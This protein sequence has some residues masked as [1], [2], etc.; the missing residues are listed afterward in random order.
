MAE[1][2]GLSGPTVK[3]SAV[4]NAAILT[5]NTGIT[6]ALEVL[7][8]D[9]CQGESIQLRLANTTT[10]QAPYTV[11]VNGVTYNATSAGS[12]FA[13]IETSDRTI[14][15]SGAMP[16][17]NTVNDGQSIEVGVKFRSSVAGYIKGIRFYHGTNNS[18][19]YT[20]HL[21]SAGGSLLASAVFTNVT[22][23]PGW[24]EVRF[25]TPVSIAA[26]TTYVASYYS[27]SGY[28]A[29]TS[30]GLSAAVTNGPLTALSLRHGRAQR[31]ICLRRRVPFRR[32]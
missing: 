20:G 17:Q 13:S 31:C 21:W 27:T 32:K 19:T 12:V 8:G 16:V 3:A 23:T 7:D 6:A 25:S 28:F 26:N 14:W 29:I 5:V 15:A 18:G 30:A 1:G 10:G 2:T 22:T 9:L 24:Q 4:S 11:V